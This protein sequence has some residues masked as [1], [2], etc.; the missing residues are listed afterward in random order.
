MCQKLDFCVNWIISRSHGPCRESSSLN[1][2]TIT[3]THTRVLKN[4]P[5][6]DSRNDLKNVPR[7]D[8]R[9]DLKN[10]PKIDPRNDLKNER[11]Y[12]VS[13]PDPTLSRGETFLARRQ[14][15]V[16]YQLSSSTKNCGNYRSWR[17]C[18]GTHL[19]AASILTPPPSLSSL[20]GSTVWVT[21]SVTGS[22]CLS[23]THTAV[24]C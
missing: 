18:E 14:T 16:P 19:F 3:G 23:T 2:S 20:S 6:I 9:N 15:R 8:P 11:S 1:Q 21:V 4:V 17:V 24:L 5:R 22:W 10:V 7:I 13:S 12:I